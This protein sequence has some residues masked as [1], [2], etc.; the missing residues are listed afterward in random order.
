MKVFV[1]NLGYKNVYWPVCR[2]ERVITLQTSAACFEHWQRGDRAGWIEWATQ[3]VSSLSGQ[4][5][6]APVASRWFNL[7]TIIFETAGDLWLH[8]SDT[9]LFWTYSREGTPSVTE[10]TDP[11]GSKI[12]YVLI[13]R[14]ADAWQHHD[15]QGRRLQWRSVHPK[16]HDFLQT[17]ATY[18]ELANDRGYRD[19]A[20][21]LVEGARLDA[22]HN[23]EAW[24]GRVG[25]SSNVKVFSNLEKTIYRAVLTVEHTVANADG[26]VDER[27]RKLKEQLISSPEL[28]EHLADQYRQREGLCAATGLQMLLDNEEGSD[29]FRLSIDRIDSNGHYEPSNLQLVCRFAN[30]WKSHRDDA[31]FKELI[32]IVRRGS[33]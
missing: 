32:T 17:E 20:E 31:R 15:K 9:D 4:I 1:A 8:R 11:V 21:A 24:K 12:N 7:V 10:I 26:S 3:N 6:T 28:R 27:V 18:Q 23:Q 33:Y 13:R 14:P 2:E 22:W 5:A 30:F 16:A 29:D 19:Y 25:N